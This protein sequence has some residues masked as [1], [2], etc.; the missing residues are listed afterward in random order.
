MSAAEEVDLVLRRLATAGTADLQS[1]RAVREYVERRRAG[2]TPH[3][4]LGGAEFMGRWIALGDGVYIPRPWTDQMV[5][6]GLAFLKRCRHPRVA[7]DI[8]TGSGA[9]AAVIAAA[10]ADCEVW[11]L[12]VHE[13]QLQW[14]RRN[15]ADLPAVTVLRSDLFTALPRDLE[16]RVDLV[17][18]SLP[19]VPSSE[20]DAMPR[21]YR[22][23]EPQVAHDGGPDGLSVDRR[24]LTDALRWLRPG[25]RAMLELGQGQGPPLAM[26][27][28]TLGY[29]RVRVRTDEDGDDLF[30]ECT[31]G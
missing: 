22:E 8:G 2:E 9:I 23:H 11:A 4:I 19:Y 28:R 15:T 30:I 16:R 7:V 25:G 13:A 1:V 21:D 10:V 31:A 18:G 14:A 3:H 5:L 26:T 24:A 20:L 29:S 12:E 6:R 27:A 17:I